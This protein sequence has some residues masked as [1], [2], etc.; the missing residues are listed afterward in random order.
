MGFLSSLFSGRLRNDDD[1]DEFEEEE[2]EE[3]GKEQA[4]E[5]KV[6]ALELPRMTDGMSLN[7]TLEDGKPLLAGQL[8]EVS[9]DKI[10][11]ERKA[12]QFAFNT[13]DP[14]SLVYIRGY[15][16]N[17]TLPF[18]LKGTVELSQ[19]IV[20][21]VKDLVSVPYDEHRSN[22]RLTIAA[23]VSLFYEEDTKFQ[24]PE[25]C[26]LVNISTGGACIDSEYIHAEGEILHMKVKLEDYA[27]M[28]FLGE[29]IRVDEPTPGLFRYGF[30]FAKL[31]AQSAQSLTRMLFNIQVGNKR[32]HSRGGPG[33]WN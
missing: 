26:K 22:F 30:L 27:E 24:N 33:A 11:I 21:K 7:V 28:T 8:A 15:G 25:K 13:C 12:G 31:D 3:E 6:K 10:T 4:D 19:R 32:T 17:G 5:K 14:G 1:D 16:S 2:E 9:G 20:L 29:I 23:P 18:D